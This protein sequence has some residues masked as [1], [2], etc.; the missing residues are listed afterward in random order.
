MMKTRRR[1]PP[2]RWK[3]HLASDR[4]TVFALLTTDA[5]RRRFW[6]ERSKEE[7]DGARFALRFIGGERIACD[8]L[9]CVAPRRFAFRYF[10]GTRVE[11]TLRRARRGGTD[12]LLVERDFPSALHHAEHHAGWVSALLCLKA[13]ADHGIDLRNHDKRRTW[14]HG[15]CEN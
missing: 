13:I 3:L 14:A 11:I 9:A 6:S 1:P 10:G 12:L 15:Y 2:V 4:E 7:R 8:V 5:G